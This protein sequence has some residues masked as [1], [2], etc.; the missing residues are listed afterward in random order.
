MDFIRSYH[1]DGLQVLDAIARALRENSREDVAADLRIS[2]QTVHRMLWVRKYY[3]DAKVRK[4]AVNVPLDALDGVARHIKQL[5]REHRN[6][7]LLEC[8]AGTETLSV[9][10]IIARAKHLVEEFKKR[11]EYEP[12]RTET[13]NVQEETD[14]NGQRRIVGVFNDHT[15]TAMLKKLQGRVSTFTKAG[16]AK[17]EA[18]AH[19]FSEAILG[20]T[21][22]GTPLRYQPGLLLPL[23]PSEGYF[24]DGKVYTFDGAGVPL[25]ELDGLQIADTGFLIATALDAD[26]KLGAEAIPIR[27]FATD[28]QRILLATELL[29]CP[30]PHCQ[31]PA[32]DCQYHHIEAFSQGG[33]TT[34]DNLVI[35]CRTH[36]AKNDDNP[37]RHKNGRVER[38]SN[39]GDPHY[40]ASPDAEPATN[41][42]PARRKGWREESKA[43]LG[44]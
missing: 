12:K 33:A 13:V 7:V 20:D 1:Q 4:A 6:P 34:T 42:H 16:M 41:P 29:V 28:L 38:D 30:Y 32:G 18:L 5:R 24:K 10:A 36:N 37:H 2:T 26:G 11:H 31:V 40:K 27:R 17:N 14:S 25:S 19:A 3:L 21:S 15:L 8:L 35:L 44:L 22:D 39:T 9:D 43:F 23:R